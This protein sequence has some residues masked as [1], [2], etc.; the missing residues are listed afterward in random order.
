MIILNDSIIT[1]NIL[2]DDLK[3]FLSILL[4]II[5]TFNSAGF[6]LV[7]LYS[8]KIIKKEMKNLVLQNIPQEEQTRFVKYKDISRSNINFIL[9]IED[10]EIRV[11]NQLFDIIR[12]VENGNS[13]TYLCVQDDKEENLIGKF[14]NHIDDN[15][16]NCK[17][18]LKDNLLKALKIL[19]LEILLNNIKPVITSG[20]ILLKL[21]NPEESIISLKITPPAPPPRTMFSI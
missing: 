8:Q 7:F 2:F 10:K 16:I 3:K 18:I 11:N 15:I 14:G 9:E 17:N 19:N 12:V 4:I 6:V 21:I 13:I 20:F 5:F 1:I